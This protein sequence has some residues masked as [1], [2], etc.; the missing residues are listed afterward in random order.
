MSRTVQ[1]PIEWL[2]KL[3]EQ[4]KDTIIFRDG[5][6]EQLDP[7]KA[8]TLLGYIGSIEYLLPDDQKETS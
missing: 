4:S 6:L 1:I 2:I 3:V 8:A 7:G 5:V